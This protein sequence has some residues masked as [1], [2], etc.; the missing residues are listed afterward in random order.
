MVTE[1]EKKAKKAGWRST[2]GLLHILSI[3]VAIYSGVQELIPATTAALITAGAAS[4][5][6]FA[7]AW[8]K[9]TP[10]KDDDAFMARVRETVALAMKKK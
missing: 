8:V 1:S 9:T 10:Q 3:I 6:G 4:S 5:F 7:N 2:S